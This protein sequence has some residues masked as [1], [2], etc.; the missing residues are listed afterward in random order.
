MSISLTINLDDATF[1]DVVALVN[2]AE[3]A[4]VTP[5]TQLKLDGNVL[6]LTVSNP[7]AEAAPAAPGGASPSTSP[8]Q[9]VGDAAIRSVI[10]ILTGKQ[11]PPR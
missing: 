5:V 6:S 4:G 8:V 9:G 11:E 10:D 1:S 2:A 3:A 7:K